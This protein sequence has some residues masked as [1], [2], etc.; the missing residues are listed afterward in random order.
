MGS[1]TGN[2][3]LPSTGV[4]C[5]PAGSG[6][7]RQG[8]PKI[9]RN[10][11]RWSS[12]VSRGSSGASW[13]AARVAA[14]VA[15]REMCCYPHAPR[16]DGARGPWVAGVAPPHHPLREEIPTLAKTICATGRHNG[17]GAATPATCATPPGSHREGGDTMRLGKY[18][19]PGVSPAHPYLWGRGG[20]S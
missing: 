15:P 8:Y 13:V 7:V 16:R 1:S 17:W 3:L 2:V 20:R 18:R 11:S 10:A 4:C 6:T 9:F 19:S 12:E 14:R 5:Y